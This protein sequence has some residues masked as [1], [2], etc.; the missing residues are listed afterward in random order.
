MVELWLVHGDEYVQE[1]ASIGL[2]ENLQNITI[3][4]DT[5]SALL[6]KYL[7]PI[8]QSN[9]QKLEEFWESGIVITKD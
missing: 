2:L 5:E 8:S 3:T 6:L 4:N 1:V 7:G 9:W